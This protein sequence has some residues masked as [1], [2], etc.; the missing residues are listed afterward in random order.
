[1][2]TKKSIIEGLTM[3]KLSQTDYS[4]LKYDNDAT[5]N[6]SVNKALL[7]DINAA[8]KSVGIVATITTAKSGHNKNV[9]GSNRTSRHMNG[10]GVD[11]AILNGKGA[12]GASNATNG[13]AEFRALGTKLKNALVSMGYTWNV[14]SGN[15]KAVLWQTNTGGN[16]YNHLHISNR[17]GKSSG[18]P[19]GDDEDEDDD[20]KEK[21]PENKNKEKKPQKPLTGLEGYINFLKTLKGE[22][23]DDNSSALDSELDQEE[24][25]DEEQNQTDD[26]SSSNVPTVDISNYKITEPSGDDKDFYSKV[27]KKL[28]APVSKQNLLFFYAWRQAEGAK[29]THN[30]F[31]TTHK[32]ENSTLWNCLKKKDG[33][34][35]AG[36]RNYKSK[37]DGVDATV[38]TIK[39]GHYGCILNGLKSDK[40]ATKIAGC[41]SDLKTW[42]TRDGILRVLNTKKINPPEI[43][44]SEVK[45]VK[46]GLNEETTRI[47][48]LMKKLL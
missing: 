47:N 1:M 4:N 43:S 42:G 41:S 14:E 15:D 12:G 37:Q 21:E 30:P 11:V 19:S 17:L 28:G 36:V 24:E 7:D 16:H 23:I 20:S 9:K 10:T 34:C 2:F 44:K 25:G 32:K 5:K 31:N 27:L 35:V 45:V 33:K 13:N 3:S 29:S 46:E 38:E 18:K 26:Q 8:A 40:G 48:D 39:N 22:K 6:D